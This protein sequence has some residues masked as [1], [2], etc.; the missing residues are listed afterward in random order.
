VRKRLLQEEKLL[1]LQKA[2]KI[3]GQQAGDKFVVM[4]VF[5]DESGP[6]SFSWP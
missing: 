6:F 1:S 5:A 2:S 4:F 3:L